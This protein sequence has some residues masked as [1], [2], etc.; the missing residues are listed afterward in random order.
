MLA[1]STGVICGRG[2]WAAGVTTWNPLDP[3]RTAGAT[4][5]PV[6]AS[7]AW[8]TDDTYELRLCFTE[9]PHCVTVI[10]QFAAGKV[11]LKFRINVSFGPTEFPQLIGRIAKAPDVG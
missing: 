6:A 3:R 7:G 10:C 2:A 9:T 5:L 8:T 1:A 11:K 4:R